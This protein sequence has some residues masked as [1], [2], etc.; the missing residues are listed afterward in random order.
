MQSAMATVVQAGSVVGGAVSGAVDAV[1]RSAASV[2]S[3]PT[4]ASGNA[5]VPFSEQVLSSNRGGAAH[6]ESST[7]EQ[8][9]ADEE[10]ARRLSCCDGSS[11][12]YLRQMSARNAA[13]PP[14][15]AATPAP[16]ASA[17]YAPPP[18]S[19]LWAAR[20]PMLLVAGVLC[21]VGCEVLVDTG[22]QSSV[23]SAA[24]M[25]R[26]ALRRSLDR[27]MQGYA[28]GVGAARII[29]RLHRVPLVL[30][31][32]EFFVS[33]TVIEMQGDMLMLGLDRNAPPAACTRASSRIIIV[34]H[35]KRA[36]SL[37]DASG[38]GLTPCEFVRCAH[39]RLRAARVQVH[40]RP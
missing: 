38:H 3:L 37:R 27:T 24:L 8:I 11:I 2:V 36:R 35:A 1:G 5:V 22:A 23:I 31:H 9:R 32:V 28:Q 13:A 39:A 26:L 15:S 33:L 30:G 12:D 21:G 18:P 14:P 4:P 7:A 10:L 6:S 20:A 19:S 29:G 34:A 40:R 17:Q 25:D 16:S